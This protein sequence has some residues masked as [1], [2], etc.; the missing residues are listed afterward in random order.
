[1]PIE[2]IGQ[3]ANRARSIGELAQGGWQ[4]AARVEALTRFLRQRNARFDVIVHDTRWM[5]ANA[6]RFVQLHAAIWDVL[7]EEVLKGYQQQLQ[8]KAA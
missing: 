5:E 2:I 1:M 4:T 8:V 6:P 3:R 7:R